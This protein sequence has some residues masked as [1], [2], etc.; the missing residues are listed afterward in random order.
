MPPV[1]SIALDSLQIAVFRLLTTIEELA[2]G[3]GFCSTSPAITNRTVIK[4]ETAGRFGGRHHSVK[5]G[6]Q[7]CCCLPIFSC[8]NLV[9]CGDM[10]NCLS[11]LDMVSTMVC[12][13]CTALFTLLC[14][15]RQYLAARWDCK[16]LI[17]NETY[18]C[19][20]IWRQDP[21]AGVLATHIL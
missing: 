21:E 15:W 14:S 18:W 5:S 7:W 3:P 2:L 4:L 20:A 19:G 13:C 6:F 8:A 17:V 12:F 1:I 16:L 11:P 9:G 10:I